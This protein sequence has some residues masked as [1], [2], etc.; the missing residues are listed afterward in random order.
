MIPRIET[1]KANPQKLLD[2]IQDAF[3]GKVVLPEFQRSFVWSREDIEELLVSI[4]QGYFIGTFLMLDTPPDRA[5]FPFRTVEGLEKVNPQA[6]P[7]DHATIRLVLDGQ[8]RLTSLFYVLYEP[9]IPLHNSRNPYR[10][11]LRL[12]LILDGNPDDAVYGI[13]LADRRRLSEMERMVEKGEAIRFSLFRDSSRFYRWLHQEQKALH[14]REKEIVEGFYQ[15][16]ANFLVPV[17]SISPEAG[18]ENIVNIF[19]RINRTGVSLSLFDLAAAR[20]Y[21]KGIRLRDLWETFARHNKTLAR[22][23]K[24]EFVL[25][26]IAIWENKEPRKSTLLDVIDKLDR[27]R[28]EEQWELACY[29]LSQA[30]QRMTSPQGY[31]AF[32]ERWIPYTTLMVPLAVLLHWVHEKHGGEEMYRKVDRWYWA[33]VFTQRY[34]QAVDTTT[35]RDVREVKEWLDGGSCPNWLDSF[36]VEQID[37]SEVEE[38][39]SSVYRG[40]M[41]LIV[42]AGAKDFINGQA[43]VLAECQDDHIFPKAKYQHESLVNSILNRTLISS[44]SNQIK[45]NKHPSEYLR[46]LLEK[47]ERDEERLRSTLNSHLISDEAQRAMERDDFPAFIEARKLTLQEEITRRVKGDL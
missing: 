43:A 4:L 17:V 2:V 7:R 27:T 46:L 5:L 38:Q 35:Y 9:E 30:H 20:L 12:D 41:C 42:L 34:D 11:F 33:S 1:P 40:V 25:K 18:K 45:S 15:R 31:G 3:Y 16:F 6:N 24:P 13:S 23:I 29:W 28:F 14:E 44:T 26:A 10:F 37:L 36:H 21:P 32:D 19:E 47:H 8:Q 39:R 22:L